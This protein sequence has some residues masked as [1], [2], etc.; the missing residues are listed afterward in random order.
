MISLQDKC[1][2]I[3]YGSWATAIVKI[4]T[5][6]GIRVGWHILNPDVKQSVETEGRNCKY[7]RDVDLDVSF[8]EASD[9]INAVVED[10]KVV[11]LAMPSAFIKKV[12][13]PLAVSLG[14]KFVI[15]AVKGIVPD[16]YIPITDY[17]IS[18]YAVPENQVAIITGPSHA[19]EVGLGR[20]SYLTAVSRNVEVR[21]KMVEMFS[22]PYIRVMESDDI[23]GVEYAAIM[24]NIYAIAVGIANG[25]GY[26]DNFIAVLI[27]NCAAEMSRM[28][29]SFGGASHNALASA[30]LGDLL[31]TCYSTYSRNRR[32][33]LLIGRG[34]T[35]RS[36]MNEMTMV[37]EGY[38]AAKCIRH[39]AAQRNVEMPIADMVYEV[40]YNGA[41]AR[42][43]L[44]DLTTKLK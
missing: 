8:I 7:L 25:L 33:G 11:V 13:E 5:E 18:H 17:V 19:E 39:T 29:E 6:N 40:L 20:W 32:F 4:L 43:Q 21:A 35:V 12:M 23:E 1:A 3:G 22:R 27:A 37:A 36:A 41:S 44:R 24:K 30:C 15:S 38:Y 2:V 31:V 14:D 42:R 28:F 10:A 26:G 34:C 9:D 16:D